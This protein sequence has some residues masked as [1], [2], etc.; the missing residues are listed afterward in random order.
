MVFL[1]LA[2]LQTV[3]WALWNNTRHLCFTNTKAEVSWDFVQNVNWRLLLILV[4]AW[5]ATLVLTSTTAAGFY[6]FTIYSP[7]YSGGWFLNSQSVVVHF[8]SQAQLLRYKVVFSMNLWSLCIFQNTS[9]VSRDYRPSDSSW[10]C[11]DVLLG[12]KGNLLDFPLR[13]DFVSFCSKLGCNLGC[14]KLLHPQFL[15][16]GS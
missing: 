1:V 3:S 15:K 12:G 9:L 13:I 10:S 16:C 8:Q 4:P 2:H 5:L 14:Q 7:S 6:S 11:I